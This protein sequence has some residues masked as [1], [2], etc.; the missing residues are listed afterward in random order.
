MG[1]AV[2]EA[3]D[4]GAAVGWWVGAAVTRTGGSADADGFGDAA[5]CA[6][7]VASGEVVGGGASV[8][9]AP[10][11]AAVASKQI[12][13]QNVRV[14]FR[15]AILAQMRPQHRGVPH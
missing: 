1:A 14:R 7:T 12:A 10:A 9:Q 3:K 8:P 6:V 2:G 5:L 4:S 15:P 13:A 11:R